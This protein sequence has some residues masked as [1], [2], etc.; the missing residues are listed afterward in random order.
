MEGTPTT[1]ILPVSYMSLDA[2]AEVRVQMNTYQAEYGGSPAAAINV[3]TK[4]GTQLSTAR[5]ITTCAMKP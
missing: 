2:I 4:G 5:R 3:I 1:P